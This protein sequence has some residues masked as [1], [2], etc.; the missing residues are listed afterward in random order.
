[1]MNIIKKDPFLKLFLNIYLLP[2]NLLKV[3][4]YFRLRHEYKKN[5]IEIE[6]LNKELNNDQN[7]ADY[8]V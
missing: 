6:V 4:K 5:Q 7:G 3:F 2:D 1:M 8:E